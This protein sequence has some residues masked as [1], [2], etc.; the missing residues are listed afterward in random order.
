M[1]VATVIGITQVSGRQEHVG[2]H[3]L[4][5][6]TQADH[7]WFY[8]ISTAGGDMLGHIWPDGLPSGPHGSFLGAYKHLEAAID[9]VRQRWG[10]PGK[11]YCHGDGNTYTRL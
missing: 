3:R 5:I 9:A 4:G 6:V 8:A 7:G 10:H 1:N 2:M 11:S